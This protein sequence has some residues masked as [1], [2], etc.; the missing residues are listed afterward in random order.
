MSSE[1][2]ACTM[3]WMCCGRR[4]SGPAAEPGFNDLSHTERSYVWHIYKFIYEHITYMYMCYTYLFLYMFI[5]V[6][7]YMF[8]QEYWPF[9]ISHMYD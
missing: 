1:S 4:P 3:S 9:Y 8:I 7:L 6:F 2:D 5:Y